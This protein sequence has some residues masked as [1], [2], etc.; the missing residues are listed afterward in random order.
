MSLAVQQITKDFGGIRA[1]DEVTFEI[2]EG[3]IT[4][5]IG[6]NGSGK[7]TLFNILTGF[8]SPNAGRII[9]KGRRIDGLEP[10]QIVELGIIRTF[11]ITRIFPKLSLLENLLVPT[12]TNSMSNL[13][14]RPKTPEKLAKAKRLLETIGLEDYMDDPASILSYGQSKLLELTLS[15]MIDAD[16]VLLD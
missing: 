15:F 3:L 4:G 14:K 5:V 8:L 16:I 1:L 12:R 2:P 7:T 9:C 6:P 10:H 11:Q 13:L